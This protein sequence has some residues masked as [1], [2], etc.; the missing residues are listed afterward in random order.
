MPLITHTSVCTSKRLLARGVYEFRFT[1]PAGFTFQPGQFILFNVPLADNPDDIQTRA[2]SIASAPAEAEL[3]FIS[4]MVPGGRAS[5][6]ME[7]VLEEGSKVTFT[8]PF[9]NFILRETD[10]EFLFVATG[11][12]AAPFRPMLVD[13]LTKGSERRIDI[14]LCVKSEEDLFWQ[15]D[16][17]SLTR[18]FPNVHSHITL[19]APSSSWTGH[20]GRVQTV[21]PQIVK[22][23]FSNK[24]LYVCGN[25]DMTKDVKRL[26]LE[27]WG[28]EKKDVHV[29]GYI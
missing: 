25:P 10:K 21:L 3:L 13:L 26:A 22:N 5:R 11:T 4:K 14:L 23:D 15:A 16:I 24:V 29:E 27:E 8:G 9:G 18:S 28:M 20:K 19:S 12:G 17:E 7:E 2:F 1:K 6:W